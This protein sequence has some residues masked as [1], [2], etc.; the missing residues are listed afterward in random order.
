MFKS[1]QRLSKV[2]PYFHLLQPEGLLSL[3]HVHSL[4]HLND[5]FQVQLVLI[6][7]LSLLPTL[8]V[9]NV[10]LGDGSVGIKF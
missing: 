8:I 3:V 7:C 9:P 5:I 6:Y 1:P 2:V 10:Y 4:F